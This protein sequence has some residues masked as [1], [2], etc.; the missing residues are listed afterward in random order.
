MSKRLNYLLK[1]TPKLLL[2]FRKLNIQK[3]KNTDKSNPNWY[4]LI[5]NNNIPQTQVHKYIFILLFILF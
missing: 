5:S 3:K 1:R 2:L 4:N